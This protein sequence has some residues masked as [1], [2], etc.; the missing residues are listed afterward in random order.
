MEGKNDGDGVTILEGLI[1][2]TAAAILETGGI[3]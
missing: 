3:T 1:E 2:Q